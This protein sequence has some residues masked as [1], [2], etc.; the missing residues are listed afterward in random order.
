MTFTLSSSPSSKSSSA[1]SSRAKASIISSMYPASSSDTPSGISPPSNTIRAISWLYPALAFAI[2]T[3]ARNGTKSITTNP[4]T[5]EAANV[6]SLLSP[7]NSTPAFTASAAIGFANLHHLISYYLLIFLQ[8]LLSWAKV[9][10]H[11]LKPMPPCPM[12]FSFCSC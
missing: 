10:C 12:S 11:K 7:A 1:T 8:S 9:H 5:T 2:E 3:S 6:R 4:A